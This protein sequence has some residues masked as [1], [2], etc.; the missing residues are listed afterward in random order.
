[1]RSLPT[2][3]VVV[4]SEPCLRPREALAHTRK[5]CEPCLRL[6]SAG[7]EESLKIDEL[8]ALSTCL[9]PTQNNIFKDQFFLLLCVGKVH[10]EA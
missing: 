9:L 3:Q 4:R 7:L 1:M 8:P 10:F 6:F 2:L 5:G